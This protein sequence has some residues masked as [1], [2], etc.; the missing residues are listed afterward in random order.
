MT[1]H[2]ILFADANFHGDHRHIF[3]EERDLSQTNF[4]N[5]VSSIAILSGTWQ[6]FADVRFGNPFNVVL[7]PGLYSFVG[8]FEIKND[9]MSSLRTTMSQPTMAGEP[10]TAHAVIFVDNG[11]E[12]D[13]RHVFVPE[14]DLSN[15]NFDNVTSSIVVELGNWI[16]FQ[17][18]DFDGHYPPVLG[19]GIYPS[20][21]ALS[22]A[23]DS[24][25]SLRPTASPSTVMNAVDN[26]VILFVDEYFRGDH[27]HVLLPQPDLASIGFDNTVSSLVVLAGNWQFFA[28]A[29]FISAYLGVLGVGE[30]SF[31]VNQNIRNDDMSSLRPAIGQSTVVGGPNRGHVILFADR[32][33]QGAHRHI[34]NGEADLNSI[35]F[36]NT[37][38]SLVVLSGSWVFF[39]NSDF[40][41]DYPVI[42]G[43]G[44][45]I[46]V[47]DVQI[48]NDD[49]SSLMVTDQ[50]ATV[51]P[52]L[53]LDA[54]IVLFEH[55]DFHG[56]HRHLFMT[57]KD[58][59]L[60]QFDNV[61]SSLAILSGTWATFADPDLQRPYDVLLGPGLYPWVEKVGIRNDDLSSLTPTNDQPTV[62]PPAGVN[63]ET[64]LFID[65]N[66]HGDH[67]HVFTNESDL[68]AGDD[69]SFN[70]AVSSL[71]VI[72]NTWQFF[73]DANFSRDYPNLL[74]EGLF[75]WVVDVGITNDDMSSLA[76][77]DVL[78]SFAGNAAFKLEDPG[79]LP[80]MPP[81]TAA[82]FKVNL[83][84]TDRTCRL[85]S[86]GDLAFGM[87]MGIN[88]TGEWQPPAGVG[89]LSPAGELNIPQ[90]DEKIHIAAVGAGDSDALMTLTTGAV[91]SPQGKFSAKGSPADSQGN[92]VIVGA[93]RLMGGYLHDRDFLVILTGVL[94][95]WPK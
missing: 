16:L 87:F 61:T 77:V 63:A 9:E 89:T 92:I 19:P 46:W 64:A 67:K 14:P 48:R 59:G 69:N 51:Q 45:Y 66:L 1:S 78:L 7:G 40:N 25:S 56:D 10:L 36:D 82:N 65:I 43:P 4:D 34:F 3:E 72:R 85:N 33:L 57:Q 17:D 71:V 23:N 12:G 54:Q 30:Y 73:R 13:H 75:R 41:D 62:P 8:D 53:T 94:T 42:L 37:V 26:E 2:A 22:I 18:S 21:D 74:A 28:D 52:P 68:G 90:F 79:K 76:V 55:R 58:L 49:M 44:T 20:V 35:G 29:N 81:V 88:V 15:N 31:V 39:R 91:V 86:F 32:A 38:S 24:V 6:F 93:G 60:E 80:I 27:R 47:E 11:F 50:P 70:N 84:P 95:P 83:S 5:V